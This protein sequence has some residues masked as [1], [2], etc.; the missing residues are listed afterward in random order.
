[1]GIKTFIIQEYE[2]SLRRCLVISLFFCGILLNPGIGQ[3][4]R[5]PPLSEKDIL[6]LATSCKLGELSPS[7]VVDLIRERGLQFPVTESFL[8]QLQDVQADTSIVQALKKL[9][10]QSK[11]SYPSHAPE[12]ELAPLNSRAPAPQVGHPSKLPDERGWPEF[13]EKVRDNAMAYSDDLPNFICTQI[14]TRS[15]R[16]FPA[17]WRVVD[18][19]VADLTYF[20]KKEDYKIIS[21]GD[22][23]AKASTI[24]NL[25]GTYSTGEFG[26][27]LLILFHPHTNAKFYL[28][29]SETINGHETIRISYQVPK[30]TAGNTISYN[31][32]RKIIAAYRGRCWIDPE[33]FHVVRLE[34]KSID[35]PPDFPITR[36]ERAIDY[37]LR[38][39]GG[40]K[41]WL[42]VRAEILLVEG[43]VN[44]YA[45]N[46]IEFKKYRKYEAEVK[47]VPE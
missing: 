30:E 35:I 23:P 22:R 37:E 45:R 8:N 29:E 16:T 27:S 20:E 43:A 9:M 38:E 5:R 17:S 15:E 28:E 31:G 3:E 14:T 6:A 25:K 7:H 33:S 46:V 21:V 18:N 42:P 36:A 24:E 1:M 41:Y 39:I 26:T 4:I 2:H 12:V 19:F 40:Q 34:E 13:L 47:I 10:G 44:H 11:P 32:E